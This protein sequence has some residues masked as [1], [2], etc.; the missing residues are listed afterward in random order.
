MSTYAPAVSEVESYIHHNVYLFIESGHPGPKSPDGGCVAVVLRTAFE[1]EQGN[2]MRTILF[3]TERLTAN[4][5]ETAVFIL[6]LLVFALAASAYVLYHGLQDPNR[7]RFRLF[8]NCTVIITSVIPP[9]LPME[10][11]IAVN[12]SL[13]ALMK[14][15]VFCTEPFRIPL[16]GKIMVCCFDKTGTLTSD[17]MRLEGV[18]VPEGGRWRVVKDFAAVPGPAARVLTGCSSLTTLNG[19]VIGDPLEQASLKALGWALQEDGTLRGPSA[20]GVETLTIVARHHFNSDLKRMTVVLRAS[21]AEQPGHL[22]VVT[23]GAPESLG[24]IVSASGRPA[25]LE[26][27]YREHAAAGARVIALAFKYIKATV[28]EVKAMTRAQLEC[29]LTFSGL[30]LF[31]T[32]LKPESEPVL[33]HLADAAHPLVMITGDAALTAC[34]VAQQ[35]HITC[36]PVLILNEVRGLGKSDA[37]ASNMNESESEDEGDAKKRSAS[38]RRASAA[39][40]F[41]PLAFAAPD[42]SETILMER[43]TWEATAAQ[44]VALSQTYDLCVTGAALHQLEVEGGEELLK[45]AIPTVQ[46]FA[47]VSPDQKELVVKTLRSIGRVTLMC[48]DGTNDMGGLKAAD[49][50]VALLAPPKRKAP[51]APAA[52]TQQVQVQLAGQEQQPPGAPQLARTPEGFLLEIESESLR[53]QLMAMGFVGGQGTKLVAQLMERKLEVSSSTLSMALKLDRMEKEWGLDQMDADAVMV[54]PGDAS[55]ASPFTARADHVGPVLDIL[56]QGRCTLVTTVQMFKILGLMCLNTAYSLSVMYLNGVKLGD[57]QATLQGIL[58]TAMFFFLSNA[59][60]RKRLSI[61]RPHP[62]ILSGY[63]FLSVLFQ[64]AAHLAFLWF[65][66]S[67]AETVMDPSLKLT[68]DSEFAPNLVNTVAYLTNTVSMVR[69]FSLGSD[70]LVDFWA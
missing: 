57:Y 9:E 30:G 20:A 52:P 65:S 2:L 24:P 62:N 4:N 66:Y 45:V 58:S 63:V 19:Q 13:L 70:L 10:L 27:V 55:M 50:G 67:K 29:D 49:V 12:K 14:N 44:F 23:K 59:A 68:P 51:T 61:Q 22:L 36:R 32:P 35:V 53:N 11:T 54:K 41:G 8:L 6:F 21:H 3:S 40:Q 31:Q 7:S 18:A 69:N 26:R 25:D 43:A 17:D 33:R 48:G 64:S 47:R 28:P 37:P 46:V 5:L 42:E 16:A 60:P 1:T 56:R 39:A 15:S 38:T 34:H